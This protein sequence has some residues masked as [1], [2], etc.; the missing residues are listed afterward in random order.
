MK[1]VLVVF[2][3]LCL[4]AAFTVVSKPFGFQNAVAGMESSPS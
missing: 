4:V 1:K 2:Y 3:A